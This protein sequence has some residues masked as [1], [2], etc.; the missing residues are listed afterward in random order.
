MSPTEPTVIVTL[1]LLKHSQRSAF[2]DGYQLARTQVLNLLENEV[3]RVEAEHD[4]AVT[5]RDRII[6][7]A[8]QDALLDMISA[9][10][11]KGGY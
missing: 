9:I 8:R 10:K 5:R 2:R 11:N 7:E 1:E 6:L 4:K 3:D